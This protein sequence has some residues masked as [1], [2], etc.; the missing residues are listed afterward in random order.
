METRD[1]KFAGSVVSPGSAL[2]LAVVLTSILAIVGVLFIMMARVDKVSTSAISENRELNLAIDTIIAEISQQLISDIPGVTGQEYHDYPQH[3]VVAGPDGQLGTQDDLVIDPGADLILGTV[4]DIPVYQTDSDPW[5]AALAPKLKVDCYETPLDDS[6]DIV[7]FS[8]IT[9][10]YGRLAYLFQLGLTDLE[11]DRVS[12][13]N[14]RAKIIAPALPIRSEGDKADADGDGVADSRWIIIPDV[15]SSKGKPIHAAIRAVDNQ[16]MLNVNAG[17]KFDPNFVDANL[18]D[19]SSQLQINLMALANRPYDPATLGDETRLLDARANYGLGGLN[20]LDLEAYKRNVIWQYTL[21]IGSLYTPFDISDELELRNRFVLDIVDIDSRIEDS[22]RLWTNAFTGLY[23]KLSPYNQSGQLLEWFNRADKD[24]FDPC[25]IIYSYRHIATTYNIDRIIDPR[26]GRMINVNNGNTPVDIPYQ[27]YS[28][29]FPLYPLDMNTPVGILY[30]R[31]LSS[32]ERILSSLGPVIVDPNVVTQYAQLAVNMVDFSDDDD[33]NNDDVLDFNCVTYL[34]DPYGFDHYGFE[35]QPFITEVAWKIDQPADFYAVELYNPSSKKIIL[36][37]NF[38]LELVSR[39]D[40][41]YVIPIIFDD[42]CDIIDANSHFVIANNLG[43]FTLYNTI[44]PSNT[45]NLKVDPALVFFGGRIPPDK[46]KPVIDIRPDPDKSRP[47]VYGGRAG[48]YDLYLRRLDV[49]VAGGIYVDKQPIEPNW[50]T[51]GKPIR[52]FGRDDRDWRVI[53]YFE[54]VEDL[55]PGGSLGM[56]NY[57]HIFSMPFSIHDFSFFLPNP[58]D[59]R[60]E[61]ITVGDIPRIL[62]L[63]HGV[64]RSSTIGQQLLVTELLQLSTAI[65][66]EHSVRLDLQNPYHRDVFQYLTVFDPTRDFIDNDSDGLGIDLD[67][68]GFLDITEIDLDEV[69]IPGRININTAPWYVIAQLPWMTHETAQALVA[70]RD[71]LPL[72]VDYSVGRYNAIVTNP[73]NADFATSFVPGTV[74]EQPGFES[75]GELN[76]IIAGLNNFNIAQYALNGID[77]LLFPDLTTRDDDPPI[78]L[79]DE[80]VDDFEERDVIFSRISNLVSVRSDVFTAYIL[81]RIGADGPQKRVIAILDRSGVNKTNVNSPDG[82]V[83]IVAL[84]HVPDPR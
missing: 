16:A 41:S 79:G 31:L 17:F 84:Q 10:L 83:R 39:E 23:Y 57:F 48:S 74:R 72:P 26:G 29:L 80:V 69:K 51:P 67:G 44:N 71:K 3:T 32:Y 66:Q 14:M 59:P 77:L 36:R 1:R 37:D 49:P 38:I 24:M 12:F 2:I 65:D 11:N 75:I 46:S 28:R 73:L 22:S 7:G 20:P 19:G 34:R 8:H 30:D 76:F 58:L 6:D 18:I 60:A 13:R 70:Y 43:A 61:L 9:D 68:D 27:R 4:D 78:D 63:G 35:A 56:A 53:Y 62:T 42:P 21:P 45:T 33:I 50:A 81:V 5:L 64:T 40:P 47:P 55:D 25:D 52:A 82:K 54:L 15:T